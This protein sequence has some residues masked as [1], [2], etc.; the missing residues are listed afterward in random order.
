[1]SQV[2]LY[3]GS[4]ILTLLGIS[5]LASTKVA[6]KEYSS[7]PSEQQRE[8]LMQWIIAGLALV[9]VGATTILVTIYGDGS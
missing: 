5:H 8:H 1:M 3:I 6:I 9:L 7:L 4:A 2:F